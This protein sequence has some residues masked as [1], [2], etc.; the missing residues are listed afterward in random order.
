MKKRGAKPKQ[1]AAAPKAAQPAAQ[2]HSLHH[3]K[4]TAHEYADSH[5]QYGGAAALEAMREDH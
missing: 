5:F 3:R 1:K 4:Q 2:A